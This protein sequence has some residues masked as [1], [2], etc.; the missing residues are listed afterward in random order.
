MIE[1]TEL[2]EAFQTLMVNPDSM[3]DFA[4]KKVKESDEYKDLTSAQLKNLQS[5]I[6]MEADDRLDDYDDGFK[7]EF[8]HTFLVNDNDFFKNDKKTLS[9]KYQRR[10][11][12]VGGLTNL[13]VEDINSKYKGFSE[14]PK[15]NRDIMVKTL[16][17]LSEL[18]GNVER[19]DLE[20]NEIDDSKTIQ[21]DK[22]LLHE[23][24]KNFLDETGTMLTYKN[25]IEGDRR[26][27]RVSLKNRNV[28]MREINKWKYVIQNQTP[29]IQRRLQPLLSVLRPLDKV[30]EQI[31]H[32]DADQI[33][34]EL[35]LKRL[36]RRNR[37]YNFWRGHK[38]KYND[39]K[40]AYNACNEA[41]LPIRDML[42]TEENKDDKDKQE[43]AEVID[44]FLSFKSIIN[45]GEL[46][47]VVKIN[48]KELEPYFKR[49]KGLALYEKF[50]ADVGLDN[51]KDTSDDRS[52]RR[53]G[54]YDK[55]SG[56]YKETITVEDGGETFD[57][58]DAVTQERNV[59][60][61]ENKKEME[62][63]SRFGL[64][65]ERLTQKVDPLFYHAFTK[66]SGAFKDT[67]AF[68]NDI[69]TLREAML[70]AGAAREMSTG[71]DMDDEIND[72]VD[73]VEKTMAR[74]GN[75]PYYLP[76]TKTV[77]RFM[78]TESW[79]TDDK[80]M[81]T[82][83]G[84]NNRLRNIGEFLDNLSKILDA[85][86]DLDRASAPAKATV[87]SSSDGVPPQSRP[88]LGT[89]NRKDHLAD[90]EEAREEFDDLIQ[91]VLDYFVVAISG[92]NKP[93]D[94]EFPFDTKT[95]K[96]QRIFRAL[97]TGR[98]DTA[99]FKVL[100][101]EGRS[102]YMMVKPTELED[103]TRMLEF[104]S[105]VDDKK[106]MGRLVNE[107][108]KGIKAVNFVLMNK[109]NS[110]LS[111]ETNIE[112]GSY[113]HK[114]LEA[115]NIDWP[116]GEK[117]PNARGKTPAEWNEMYDESKVY[118]FEAIESH[119]K[120]NVGGY[121][122]SKRTMVRGSDRRSRGSNTIVQRFII[123]V[124][125]MKILRS[126]LDSK[127]LDAHDNIRKMLGKPVYY[128]TGKVDNYEHIH[129]AMLIMKSKYN[130]DITAYEIENIVTETN[131]MDEL[132]KKHG[133]PKEGVYFLK[134]NFR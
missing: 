99:L 97:A 14:I 118:P 76:L 104:L 29:A 116:E 51:L 75:G 125:D 107:L 25:T 132:S 70:S 81:N 1:D 10:G 18:K 93:F 20:T 91:E 106:D 27:T 19:E 28:N 2:Y 100:A 101:L 54:Y 37:I 23:T 98:T 83:R 94:D 58:D 46:D 32:L 17:K 59:R 122:G 96:T 6:E 50:I 33:I 134:A 4:E 88:Q 55:D 105:S 69:N 11:K 7:P 131:S 102:G 3:E 73:A 126:D 42:N 114:V 8:L 53:E 127:L 86:D 119:I 62:E 68:R 34:G 5:K 124:D 74:G 103:L 121:S 84:I 80:A 57:S 26:L 35:D 130:V 90:I 15:S 128:N 66:D 87:G 31:I 72:Y 133:V 63:L 65:L 123:A 67:V 112:F 92:S 108:T 13:L 40:E 85:G 64:K 79:N 41:F 48:P 71:V 120:R 12:K 44:K 89:V 39:F 49:H 95:S 38:G 61:A 43:I 21:R 30:E 60:A 117:F 22:A 82:E 113:L 36:D 111:Q 9:T 77:N 52:A 110:I 24:L 56:D 16:L 115:N 45:N 78:V 129:S 47:Y 109:R